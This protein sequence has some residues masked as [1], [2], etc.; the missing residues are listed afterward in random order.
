M[1]MS[2]RAQSAYDA[3]DYPSYSYPETHP[4]RMAAMAILHGLSP[5]PANRCRV[6]EIGCNEGANLIPMAYALPESEFVGFDLAALPVER[7]QKRI[8]ALGLTNIRIFVS[9]L[10][11]VGGELGRFD[12]ILAHGLYAWVPE[13]V[14]D[15]LLALC[16]ELLTPGGVAFVSY[17]ALP[18]GHLRRMTREMMLFGVKQIADAK[19]RA[20][21]ARGLL[22]MV[23]EARPEG[24]AY[25]QLL[26]RQVESM[27]KRNP[28]TIYHDELAE[29]Y[30]PVL[31]TEFVEHAGK[32]GLQYLSE[33]SLPPPDD[34]G[35]KPEFQQALE[36]VAGSDILKRE[37]MMDFARM[38][39][40]RETLLCRSERVV[41]R[42]FPADHLRRLLVASQTTSGA[43]QTAGARE[44]R[45]PTG[46]KLETNHPGVIAL[47]EMLEAAWPHVLSLEELEPR[48]QQ[49]GLALDSEGATL[50]LQLAAARMIVFHAWKAPLSEGISARPRASA[51]SR[52]EAGM[53][54]YATTLGHAT[55]SMRDPIVRSLFLLLD[56]TRD[57]NALLDTMHSA[58]PEIPC[59][60]LGKKIEQALEF[61]YQSAL[62]EA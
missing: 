6:L 48:L 12:Y 50:L 16:G 42:D 43:G 36:S 37:Q 29:E 56:G 15:R 61:F 51:A 41:Q 3:V 28:E 35:Q 10:M 22:Q 8:D 13:P 2:L 32:H 21:Q 34:A 1:Q 25:R 60:E 49:A 24:D 19:T 9:D 23:L 39:V 38:R 47:L 40:F 54:P 59:E 27:E 18:G 52:Q 7:G 45:T 46:I 20:I 53:R 33:A 30:H 17:D 44:F 14:R 31:F 5:A 57:R 26:T 4:D 62:L 58:Y 55:A 11:E